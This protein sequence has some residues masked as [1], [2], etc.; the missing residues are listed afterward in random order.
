MAKINGH[1]Y[2][3]KIKPDA[4]L[5]DKMFAEYEGKTVKVKTEADIDTA[6]ISKQLKEFFGGENKA[7]I[8]VEYD[9]DKHLLEQEKA[10]AQKALGGI[11]LDLSTENV[12]KQLDKLDGKLK[13][14]SG[15]NYTKELGEQFKLIGKYLNYLVD[16]N[17]SSK[18]A[19]DM[20]VSLDRIADK[21]KQ[22]QSVNDNI[23]SLSFD[24]GAIEKSNKQIDELTA[25][26]KELENLGASASTPAIVFPNIK[27][28][29]A[30]FEKYLNEIGG[31][32]DAMSD[33][34][35]DEF[36][37][38]SDKL[39]DKVAKGSASAAEAILQLQ[40]HFKELGKTAD[41]TAEKTAKAV[42]GAGKGRTVKEPVEVKET[43]AKGTKK[44]IAKESVNEPTAKKVVAKEPVKAVESKTGETASEINT[45][46]LE[47]VTEKIVNFEKE[48]VSLNVKIDNLNRD[49]F[50]TENLDDYLTKI[51]QLISQIK[52]VRDA[53]TDVK[54]SIDTIKEAQN[55]GILDTTK[56]NVKPYEGIIKT[57]NKDRLS[58][59][60]GELDSIS[61]KLNKLYYGSYDTSKLGKSLR[62]LNATYDDEGGSTD[63]TDEFLKKH[64]QLAKINDAVIKSNFY[65]NGGTTNSIEELNKF[66]DVAKELGIS[67]EQIGVN[68]KN[69]G[70]LGEIHLQMISDEELKKFRASLQVFVDQL[71]PIE[72]QTAIAEPPV[73][74]YNKIA[75]TAEE[76]TETV[77]IETALKKPDNIAT[78]IESIQDDVK[79]TRIKVYA[80]IGKLIK[81]DESKTDESIEPVSIPTKVTPPTKKSADEAVSSAKE[82]VEAQGKVNIKTNVTSPT[83]QSVEDAV[84]DSK[85]KVAGEGNVHIKTDVTSPTKQSVEDAVMSAKLT[86][87]KQDNIPIRTDLQKPTDVSVA[88]AVDKTREDVS[89][90]GNVDIKSDFKKPTNITDVIDE[91]QET[92]KKSPIKLNAVVETEDIAGKIAENTQAKATGKTYAS[93]GE[94]GSLRSNI[95]KAFNGA[96]K[97][98][99]F[100]IKKG[101]L[102][103]EADKVKQVFNDA[104]S[105]V[106]LHIYK[107]DLAGDAT[108]VTE[109][110]TDALKA[111]A[112]NYK[113]DVEIDQKALAEKIQNA[114]KQASLEVQLE[115]T[116]EPVN[117]VGATAE[118][119]A[120]AFNSLNE[121]LKSVSTRK[122]NAISKAIGKIYDVANQDV[123]IKDLK[124]KK[125]EVAQSE[126]DVANEKLEEADKISKEYFTLVS[127][128]ASTSE[129]FIASTSKF[130]LAV[131]AMANASKA[132]DSN[133]IN[134][135]AKAFQSFSNMNPTPTASANTSGSLNNPSVSKTDKNTLLRY[136]KQIADINAVLNSA[137]AQSTGKTGAYSGALTDLADGY[138]ELDDA[139]SRNNTSAIADA[140]AKLQSALTLAKE[141]V[142]AVKK[143]FDSDCSQINKTVQQTSNIISEAIQKG[144]VSS[145]E[146]IDNLSKIGEEGEKA[147]EKLRSATLANTDKSTLTDILKQVNTAN[148]KAKSFLGGGKSAP[149]Y[150]QQIAEVQTI[151]GSQYAIDKGYVENYKGALGNL[152]T[153]YANY[154][155]AVDLGD[156]T[157]R[158]EAETK[159]QTAL[160]ETQE[161]VKAVRKEFATDFNV[162]DKIIR[163]TSN[164]IATAQRNGLAAT[165]EAKSAVEGLRNNGD[166]ISE[167]LRSAT[168]ETTSAKQMQDLLSQARGYSSGAKTLKGYEIG[169]NNRMSNLI[170]KANSVVT[171]NTAMPSYLSSQYNSLIADMTAQ[172]NS[173][174]D[175]R[176]KEY[177]KQLNDLNTQLVATGKTGKSFATQ[178]GQQIAHN[179][180]QFVSM[181]V[182]FYDIVRYGQQIFSTVKDI[183]SALVELRKVSG[184][185]TERL[186]QSF[187]ASAETAQELGASVTDVINATAD[188]SR[189][190]YSVDQAEELAKTSQ[191]YVNVGD[192]I[193]METAQENLIST[194]QGFQIDP[195]DSSKI[196][197]SF[198][199]VANNYAIDTNGI[200]QALKRSASSFN[201]AHNT[202]DEAIAL[203][204]GANEVVQDPAKVGNAFK[205][206]SM[207]LRSS[208]TAGLLEGY[209]INVMEDSETYKS[210]YD[211]LDAIAKKWDELTDAEQAAVTQAVAAKT[212]GN[213]FNALMK[214]FDTVRE[215][216]NTSETSE[217]SAEREEQNYEKGIDYSVKVAQAK[218]QTLENEAVNSQ[219]LKSIVDW[220]NTILSSIEKVVKSGHAIPILISTIVSAL[221]TL[222]NKMV[223]IQ[224][225]VTKIPET[226]KKI[227]ETISG[228]REKGI[229]GIG[230]DLKTAFHE[231]WNPEDAP[232][233]IDK[234]LP[235]LTDDQA[236]QIAKNMNDGTDLFAGVPKPEADTIQ[237]YSQLTDEIQKYKD[238]TKDGAASAS[239]LKQAID[240]QRTSLIANKTAIEGVGVATKIASAASSAFSAVLNG[241]ANFGIGLAISAVVAGI[242]KLAN[243]EKAAAQAAKEAGEE[244]RSNVDSLSDYETQISEL[245]KTVN[246]ESSSAKEVA[247][248][249]SKLIDIEDELIK[250]YA[251]EPDAINAITEAINGNAD[252]LERVKHQ[253]AVKTATKSE[254]NTNKA[255]REVTNGGSNS[256]IGAKNTYVELREA[257]ADLA[258]AHTDDDKA[259][260]RK[261]I[262]KANKAIDDYGEVATAQAL[263]D[264]DSSKQYKG[265]QSL[266][267]DYNKAIS[268]GDKNAEQRAIKN[269][270]SAYEKGT[271]PVSG[272]QLADALD[273]ENN[274]K[275]TAEYNK[276]EKKYQDLLDKID[277]GNSFTTAVESQYPKITAE[278]SKWKF[279]IDIEAN[280]KGL[281]DSVEDALGGGGVIS[282][283]DLRKKYNANPDELDKIIKKYNFTSFGDLSSALMEQ[284]YVISDTDAKLRQ[285]LGG[286]AYKKLKGKAKEKLPTLKGTDVNNLVNMAR[287]EGQGNSAEEIADFINNYYGSGSKA[288]E[289][290]Y[291]NFTKWAG[292]NDDRKQLL[293]LAQAGQLTYDTFNQ[294]AEKTNF[295]TK[296]GLDPNDLDG[297]IKRLTQ[298][299]DIVGQLSNIQTNL[300][301]I[302]D[303]YLS[304]KDSDY[305]VTDIGTLQS[306][307]E[308][309][310]VQDWHPAEMKAWTQFERVATTSGS[311]MKEMKK[312]TNDLVKAWLQEN[313][314]LKG[315][316]SKNK[317]SYIDELRSMGITNAKEVVNTYLQAEEV[318]KTTFDH[319][320]D[321]SNAE[322]EHFQEQLELKK[323]SNTELFKTLGV[324]AA[325]WTTTQQHQYRKDLQNWIDTLNKKIKAYKKAKNAYKVAD[326]AYNDFLDSARTN[327]GNVS[328]ADAEYVSRSRVNVGRNV[329]KSRKA[330]RKAREQFN[331]T[332][333]SISDIADVDFTPQDDSS[334]NKK[335]KRASSTSSK[336][337]TQEIDWIERRLE[338]LST[339]ISLL[340]AKNTNIVEQENAKQLASYD[341]NYNAQAKLYQTLLDTNNK[342]YKK[343]LGK[344]DNYA[345]RNMKRK[346]KK[347]KSKGTLTDDLI[348]KI[349]NGEING[350]PEELI[351][352]YG[353]S[354]YNAITTYQGY[355][356]KAQT[357]LQSAEE[358]RTNKRQA[359][360]DKYQKHVDDANAK[361]EKIQ[362]Q[363]DATDKD[364]YAYRAKLDGTREKQIRESYKYQIKQAKLEN[365]SVKIAT[366]R[367]QK[368]KEIRDLHKEQSQIMQEQYDAEIAL[369]QSAESNL[370][371]DNI[372]GRNK[373]ISTQITNTRKSYNEQIRQALIDGD[374]INAKKLGEDRKKAVRDLKI[375]QNQNWA[376]FYS[377]RSENYTTADSMT[378]NYKQSADFI[379]QSMSDT[380]KEYQYLLKIDDLNGDS[381]SKAKHQL[382]LEQK[383]STANYNILEAMK[384]ESQVAL[385]MLS[386]YQAI[387]EAQGSLQTAYGRNL[388][389]SYYN[390]MI[391]MNNESIKVQEDFFN[392]Y[393]A[394][395]KDFENQGVLNGADYEKTVQDMNSANKAI[396]DLE[397][398]NAEYQKGIVENS[399]RPYGT[400]TDYLDRVASAYQYAQE[401]LSYYDTT[402][403][404]VGG[405]TNAG[406]ATLGLDSDAIDVYTKKV[407]IAENEIA[408]LVE[409][410]K[411]GSI[412]TT[413][414][415]SKLENLIDT[416]R[417]DIKAIN[418]QKEAIVS[419]VKE[420]LNAELEALNDLI[421]K[422]KDALNVSK[423]LY[424]YQKSIT[425]KTK[426]IAQIQRQLAAL[427]GNNSEEAR[428]QRQKLQSQLSEQE[429]SLKEAERDR[430][431]SD[432][433]TA[434]D[435][436]S[437]DFSDLIDEVTKDKDAIV[438]A[439]GKALEEYPGKLKEAFADIGFDPST[440]LSDSGVKLSDGT[441][442]AIS[443][444]SEILDHVDQITGFD[445][446][447]ETG[448]NTLKAMLENSDKALTDHFNALMGISSEVDANGN[449]PNQKTPG[450][451]NLA[452]LATSI[453]AGT[454]AIN[455][456]KTATETVTKSIDKLNEILSRDK[457]SNSTKDKD[458]SSDNNA[459]NSSTESK[460]KDSGSKNSNTTTNYPSG[461]VLAAQGKKGELIQLNT[462]FA[463]AWNGGSDGYQNMIHGKS[464]DT[465]KGNAKKLHGK[466]VRILDYDNSVDAYHVIYDKKKYWIKGAAIGFKHGGIGQLVKQ[467]GEDGIAMV[468]NGEGF[469]APEH[470]DTIK[471]LLKDVGSLKKIT[472]N[473]LSSIPSTRSITT[474]IN[475]GDFNI[476]VDGSNIVDIESF[477]RAIQ[478][479]KT[480]QKTLQDATIGQITK[481]YNN[482]LNIR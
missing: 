377:A 456:A 286:D 327:N 459:G 258:V 164:Q 132:I 306:A 340:Q 80:T 252:A 66:I 318:G 421:K 261:R 358:A 57:F 68:S 255:V 230:N 173:A 281:R 177:T 435:N 123:D 454:T 274:A 90:Q 439:I 427:T 360:N 426:D 348:Q 134:Q 36:S 166:R 136:N 211:Q 238:S 328:A 67:L 125:K 361:N 468:R 118:K 363:L 28:E 371:A 8:Q 437:E 415:Q 4:S 392:K 32:V 373:E 174:T 108:K 74:E 452:T 482:A 101:D 55:D 227:P 162:I 399:F 148:T 455:N 349:Q 396:Y 140:Q 297:A 209:G 214:N 436:L 289:L 12:N 270:T 142:K 2:V 354:T 217:G 179:A 143:E 82:F 115:T 347:G 113:I 317:D 370:R 221:A 478:T 388:T 424:D 45:K 430:W 259:K 400:L 353:E 149:R 16:N 72:F 480:V 178:I 175:D 460:P 313:E 473:E 220:F 181:Y 291:K 404:D 61:E 337:T 182:S 394:K 112:S 477:K 282:E 381:N 243:A 64:K 185:S 103:E 11:D 387:I 461:T 195:E 40:S 378:L 6:D 339:K 272:K 241:L 163:Q 307:Y 234:L 50:N 147:G 98:V 393:S 99:H 145:K 203:V 434:L 359:L 75:K 240:T 31:A 299:T 365:N 107:K 279:Q 445:L 22:L 251:D 403:T 428:M 208:D 21:F 376:D 48:V 319:L 418:E 321:M 79:D 218:I 422:R 165:D 235:Q 129:A 207:R 69:I 43:A 290:T 236:G 345:K 253:E 89:D 197:D 323:V 25:R 273:A 92:V 295:L 331:K 266:A 222:Q 336:K 451:T 326:D 416:E 283:S 269:L 65:E 49:I 183:D 470:V 342:A 384:E 390:A 312:A 106:K 244:Y 51:G 471:A 117:N 39:E 352:K 194:L 413:D 102:K 407:E 382:E 366:L 401:L 170:N 53:F 351:K 3:L 46:K 446:K 467:N 146:G 465:S 128:I 144:V 204:T 293:E 159:L 246:S 466:Q 121:V 133:R 248:A 476:S 375:N 54:D 26:L 277:F 141:G 155:K 368:E 52:T 334:K 300:K 315:L 109:V 463:N 265:W 268:K 438:N 150:G 329:R 449:N 296:F 88:Y 386:S 432:T 330:L 180:A 338:R 137:Y 341:K 86:V 19:D 56:F 250:K 472:R 389:D 350:S 186:Q 239:G 228:I 85:T 275:T 285:L 364:R 469:V 29:V 206:M 320:M 305:N 10:K 47:D 292:D 130:V 411:A 356:D 237:S 372:K 412:S 417:S 385:D 408:K 324:D 17:F 280:K 395:V 213:V 309:L 190:G 169:N 423:D 154:T 397:S 184:A 87:N 124:A 379:R 33:K 153:E 256:A 245:Q 116:K 63:Q 191:L 157:A 267:N 383:R 167:E 278:I 210:T 58:K 223:N 333:N 443:N 161:G 308:Q 409:Q 419:L 34:A 18:K 355:W 41:S 260:A 84:K 193:D 264:V 302:G 433:E 104:L 219:V 284:G 224:V 44:D 362:A 447:S 316:T 62:E 410:Y 30:K 15:G 322:R 93:F 139:I 391:Q 100:T 199:E 431:Y 414:Y 226:I 131:T 475:V 298:I 176:V 71:K 111:S 247:D 402:N 13:E 442:V 343:Y 168:L 425:D 205:T 198:N 76:K 59:F 380:E 311:S 192:N 7:K 95:T 232:N 114:F 202:L 457:P 335:K 122:I 78:V 462:K 294:N 374:T 35:F 420:G 60:N 91:I 138:K 440:M 325:N 332:I 96:L 303:V 127:G 287:S 301:S 9:L 119:T 110:F 216:R 27:N 448:G 257:T 188:W 263:L 172:S 160:K 94:E 187:K 20:W 151:L 398:K 369:S 444:I 37:E 310:G 249:R 126:L 152:N 357:A 225:D 196:I 229:S 171:K 212:Q 346:G 5:M 231:W 233:H 304:K 367:A 23:E 201:A 464:T 24:T 38:M 271:N 314:T 288:S 406:F 83:K 254:K 450:G 73:E 70:N 474:S 215:A 276:A 14:L 262:K 200:G 156:E 479:D 135:L 105:A 158:I 42:S 97:D 405:L 81:G 120:T 344:A 481:N 458:D 453:D 441:A 1:E 77:P 189:L 429:E 242:Y